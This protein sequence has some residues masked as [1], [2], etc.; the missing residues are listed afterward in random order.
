MDFDFFF[1]FLRMRE[2]ISIFFDWGFICFLFVF[3]LFFILSNSLQSLLLSDML[4]RIYRIGFCLVAAF[5]LSSCL[6]F[7][8]DGF[9]ILICI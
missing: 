6:G 4:C 9:F 5:F 2:K 8:H 3:Y 7:V 1:I